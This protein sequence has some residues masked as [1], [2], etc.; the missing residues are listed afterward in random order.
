LLSSPDASF[1]SSPIDLKMSFLTN[2]SLTPIPSDLKQI[3]NTQ[4]SDGELSKKVHPA[5]TPPSSSQHLH[6]GISQLPQLGDCQQPSPLLLG[7]TDP[8]GASLVC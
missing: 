8:R 5:T 4:D 2:S 1:S 7:D 6:H 3:F